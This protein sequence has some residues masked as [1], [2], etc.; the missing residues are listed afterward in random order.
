MEQDFKVKV[1]EFEGPLGVLLDLIEK[2]KLHISQV[3]LAAVTDDYLAY[4]SNHPNLPPGEL[5]NFVLVA[6]TLMLIK[7]L[8]LLPTLEVSTEEQ[9][10]IEELERRLKIYAEAKALAEDLKKQWGRSPLYGPAKDRPVTP[11]FTL[12]PDLTLTNLQ[13]ALTEVLQSLPQINKIPETVVQKIISL[14]EVI[15][16]L[17]ERVQK[18]L[19]LKWSEIKQTSG[20]EKR[21]LIV[22]FLGLL[23]LVKQ[24]I[25]A[26]EQPEHFADIDFAKQPES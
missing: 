26:V 6:A 4:L 1:G 19:S 21:T 23:E 7:S 12:P 24:G 13:A 10:S 5:A 14:E 15:S 2:R 3:S 8:S 16:N 20:G 9:A 25:L 18:S 11:V 22:H 17:A